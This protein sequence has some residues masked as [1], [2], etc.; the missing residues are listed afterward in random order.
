[1]AAGT[2]RRGHASVGIVKRQGVARQSYFADVV[3]DVC[4][5]RASL[6]KFTGRV[7]PYGGEPDPLVTPVMLGAAA[8][9]FGDGSVAIQPGAGHFSWVD[10]PRNVRRRYRLVSRLNPEPAAGGRSG[11]GVD[12]LLEVS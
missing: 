4:A 10:D 3:F 6:T 11:E 5:I 8:P 9:F 1:V 7:L 12:P 2:T